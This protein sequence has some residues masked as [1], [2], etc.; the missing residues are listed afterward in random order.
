MVM[1]SNSCRW[2]MLKLN[3]IR[4]LGGGHSLQTHVLSGGYL[5]GKFGEV[6]SILL[7]A[8]R[9]PPQYIYPKKLKCLEENTPLFS[10]CSS[11]FSVQVPQ[12]A[13]TKLYITKYIPSID[14]PACYYL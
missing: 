12:Q 11:F 8:I 13:E 1:E 10:K 2:N 7:F 9:T 3:L 6:I 4:C 5:S 14:G